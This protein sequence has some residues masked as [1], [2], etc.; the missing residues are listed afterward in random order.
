M[1]VLKLVA[2]ILVIRIIILYIT[3]CTY[4]MCTEYVVSNFK[5]NNFFLQALGTLQMELS[6]THGRI[7]IVSV[8]VHIFI[9]TSVINIYFSSP[10]EQN[11][12]SHRSSIPPPVKRI[13]V[14]I[15]DGLRAETAFSNNS[16]NT[17]LF[18]E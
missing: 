14:F 8:V 6:Y 7:I 17:T 10:I 13:V 11:L 4:Y 15:S 1:Y 12:S 9:I 18:L 3:E 2:S 5:P 16:M